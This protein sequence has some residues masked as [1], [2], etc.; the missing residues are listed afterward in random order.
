MKWYE[1]AAFH[2]EYKE[3]MYWLCTKRT[4]ALIEDDQFL[5]IKRVEPADIGTAKRMQEI[6]KKQ[7]KKWA[8]E[9]KRMI[10]ANDPLLNID[11]I[12]DD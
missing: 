7:R 2:T 5:I 11:C 4:L 1:V 10:R 12:N 8:K 9:K 3:E 6:Q